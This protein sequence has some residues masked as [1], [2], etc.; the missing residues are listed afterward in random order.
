MRGSNRLVRLMRKI[1]CFELRVPNLESRRKAELERYGGRIDCKVDC[2]VQPL[3]APV[4][5][6]QTPHMQSNRLHRAAQREGRGRVCEIVWGGCVGWCGA[7]CVLRRRDSMTVAACVHKH[8]NP[9]T[10]YRKNVKIQ[11]VHGYKE[12]KRSRF[13]THEQSSRSPRRARS[14]TGGGLRSQPLASPG[15]GGV[16][17]ICTR[18]QPPMEA[19]WMAG[20]GDVAAPWR[21]WRTHS[22]AT[23]GRFWASGAPPS[24]GATA[25]PSAIAFP[26]A[27]S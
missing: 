16:G 26:H 19:R 9:H 24:R 1:Y 11:K 17:G 14:R 2:V 18:A 25:R 23:P 13:H 7:Y 21:V 27:S 12:S 6:F 22:K 15:W 4:W 3:G 10:K 20:P 5:W 8:T